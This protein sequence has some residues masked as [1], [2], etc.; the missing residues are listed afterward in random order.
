MTLFEIDLG[1][2]TADAKDLAVHFSRGELVLAFVDWREERRRVVF[3]DVL[4]FR[5]QELDD[6]TPRDDVAYEVKGSDWLARQAF[7]DEVSRRLA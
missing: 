6:E 4:A 2:S 1:V 7:Y 5:W 3:A